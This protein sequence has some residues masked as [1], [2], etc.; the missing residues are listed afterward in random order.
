MYRSSPILRL[1]LAMTLI[2]AST[3]ADRLGCFHQSP[4]LRPQ[5]APTTYKECS[6][7]LRFLL[8]YDKEQGSITFSR[9]PGIGYRVP[10]Y[11]VAGTCAIPI[12]M[13]SDNEV[14]EMSFHDI[15][16]EAGAIMVRC[17]MYGPHLGGTQPVG[18][19]KVMNVTVFGHHGKRPGTGRP[20]SELSSARVSQANLTVA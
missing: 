18:P 15:A 5:R 6:H 1:L 8:D 7:I 4:P 12:D 13:H 11:W 3:L 19:R 9:R 20:F 17:V 2:I 16:V 10:D 14:D